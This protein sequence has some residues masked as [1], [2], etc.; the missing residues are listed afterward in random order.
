MTSALNQDKPTSAA[1]AMPKKGFRYPNFTQRTEIGIFLFN[2]PDPGF[3]SASR[4]LATAEGFLDPSW[5]TN[6]REMTSKWLKR[7]HI[8][9][10]VAVSI[11]P[12][13]YNCFM[14]MTNNSVV[15]ANVPFKSSEKT[16]TRIKN[17]VTALFR[18]CEKS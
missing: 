4:S 13:V 14:L 5:V 18:Q 10:M 16:D 3:Y 1:S 17:I 8:V 9:N 2:N 7:N 12:N 11:K 15:A 6:K